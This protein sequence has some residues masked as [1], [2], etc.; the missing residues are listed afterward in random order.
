MNGPWYTLEEAMDILSLRA[1][2]LLYEIQQ[3]SIQPCVFV[4]KLRA[5]S[6]TFESGIELPIGQ[7]SLVY[8]GHISF[9][10]HDIMTLLAE[11]TV[12][13]PC[14]FALL[15]PRNSS[16]YTSK[17]LYKS[18]LPSAAFNDWKPKHQG[19]DEIRD[20]VY[21]PLLKET[22]QSTITLNKII[23][24][25]SNAISKSNEGPILDAP[26]QPPI[27]FIYTCEQY[28]TWNKNDLRIAK[29]EIEYFKSRANKDI[30][31]LP[32]IPLT[33][34]RENQLHSL[35]TRI[36]QDNSS[37][38]AKEIWRII[39]NEV[40]IDDPRYDIDKILTVIDADCIDWQSRHG[41]SQSLKWSSFQA[42]VSKLK[43]QLKN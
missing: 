27:D 31:T 15:E 12:V 3:D 6:I 10:H 13:S 8:S 18:P 26:E 24:D 25:I 2:E 32:S 35:I 33:G 38:G 19:R 17:Y 36:L 37:S 20:S 42:L 5:I 16:D 11:G 43:K 30:S 40:D 7:G 39:Q 23:Y 9:D 22:V 34:E 1:S 21:I 41:A 14:Y 29:S 28:G 4:N